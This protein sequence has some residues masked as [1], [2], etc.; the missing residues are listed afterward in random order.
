[1]LTGSLTRIR[2]YDPADLDELYS[3]YCDQEYAYWVSGSWPLAYLL[4]RDDFEH[5]YIDSDPHRY[6][7]AD[8]EDNPIGTVGFDQ[9]N[10]PARSARIFIG[11]GRK[12]L[13]GN[14]FGKDALRSFIR[15]MFKQWNFNRITAETWEL[16]RRAISCYESLGFKTE[17]CLR[18]AY[19]V[20]GK[21]YNAIVLGLLQ[22][23]FSD[24]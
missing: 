24:N 16:N 14:G 8:L 19:Y 21:Y 9:V 3:W 6:V 11:I 10:T 1:M 17:G 7:I 23:E 15:F 20:D 2:P 13:W 18:Q 4:R 22:H 12:E 5:E